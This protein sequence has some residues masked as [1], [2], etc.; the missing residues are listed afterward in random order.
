MPVA[1]S[2]QDYKEP[3]LG[4]ILE[5]EN[6][7]P[8]LLLPSTVRDHPLYLNR[9]AAGVVVLRGYLN[10]ERVHDLQQALI[11]FLW[12]ATFPPRYL[13]W[14]LVNFNMDDP[15]VPLLP[16]LANSLLENKELKV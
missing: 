11:L 3:L 8:V 14:G 10:Q 12:S 2:C 13:H 15:F 5:A 16:Q 1:L 4:S 6:Q 7:P 9:I